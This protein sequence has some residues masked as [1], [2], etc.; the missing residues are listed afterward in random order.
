MA[1]RDRE[2]TSQLK[3]A[4]DRE[5]LDLPATARWREWMN[6]VEAVI[7]AASEPVG[8]EVL[9]Q[10]VGRDCSIDL[11][12][13]D[14]R[15]EL[16]M[17]P[18]DLVRVAGGFQHRTRPSYAGAIRAAS[19]IDERAAGL[20]PAQALVLMTIAYFQPLTRT[21][22][23]TFIGREVSRDAIGQLRH[24]GFIASGPRSPQPGAPYTYITTDAFLQHFGFE[25]LRDL[26][27]IEKL[28]DAGLL[29]KEKL[30]ADIPSTMEA[31][32]EEEED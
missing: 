18:Y 14:I 31:V 25:T 32:E 17:R 29:D 22:L 7:F 1:W 4:F 11:L 16:R 27:D 6:R 12:I 30:L 23:S 15:E 24:A 13:E 28:E 19:C 3:D 2:K 26:P 8:V 5:L 20:S 21:E 10:L 9:K